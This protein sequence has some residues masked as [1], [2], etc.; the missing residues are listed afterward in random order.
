MDELFR[1]NLELTFGKVNKF[2]TQL[3]SLAAVVGLWLLVS[4]FV[5]IR[6]IPTLNLEDLSLLLLAS[7]GV[8]FKILFM[9]LFLLFSPGFFAHFAYFQCPEIKRKLEDEVD[10]DLKET[11]PERKESADLGSK[12]EDIERAKKLF[13]TFFGL[14]FGGYVAFLQL[15]MEL[16]GL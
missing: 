3:L 5:Q 12:E 1:V 14:Y 7:T 15:I 6:Y 16:V 8:A 13:L 10:K 11:G 9:F 2:I 4:Y